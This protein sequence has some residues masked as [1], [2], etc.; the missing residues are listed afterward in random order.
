MKTSPDKEV[1]ELY[2][3]T[4]NSYSKMMDTEIELP[5]YSDTFSRLVDRIADISGTIIDTSCGPGHMLE[6]YHDKYDSSHSF[7]GVDV[8]PNMVKIADK[9]LG[10]KAK[11]IVG[12]MLDLS[13]IS[14]SSSAAVIS[15]F[16][17]HH[18]NPEEIVFALR[19]WHRVLVNQ[20]QLIL[21]V[22]EGEGAIDYG[23]ESDIIA[24]RFT[25]DQI[26]S[27][28]RETGFVIDRCIVDPVEEIPM[29]AIY[30]EA[31]KL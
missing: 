23:N 9:R 28:V 19:E 14:S 6:L 11:T 4:T 17:I 30:L 1:R 12:N 16:A 24:L 26:E 29:D 18:L 3:E 2:D 31:S 15:F 25:Q 10:D 8:S 5:I 22:W 13:M 20:G 27:W 7:I 21:A